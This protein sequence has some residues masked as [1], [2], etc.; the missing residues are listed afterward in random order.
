MLAEGDWIVSAR[1]VSQLDVYSTLAP[2]TF[3]AVWTWRLESWLPLRTT[4]GDAG[5]GFYSHHSGYAP[6]AWSDAP[7]EV[8]TLGRVIAQ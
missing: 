6:F 8:I 4:N 7:V 1:N 3:R 2:Y 5:A